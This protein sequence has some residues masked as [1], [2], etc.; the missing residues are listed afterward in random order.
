MLSLGLEANLILIKYKLKQ[1]KH[2]LKVR[3]NN[4]NN[5]TQQLYRCIDLFKNM[6]KILH[7]IQ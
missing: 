1:S 3:R 5:K 2:K 4:N 6:L 7:Y